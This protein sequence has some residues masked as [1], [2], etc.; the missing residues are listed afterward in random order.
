MMI[1]MWL[2]SVLDGAGSQP[3]DDLPILEIH[4]NSAFW[5][6]IRIP[7]F[8][9]FIGDSIVGYVFLDASA[10]IFRLATTS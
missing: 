1:E 3:K 4:G 7:R 9:H 10:A 2:D 8:L 5:E 6:T